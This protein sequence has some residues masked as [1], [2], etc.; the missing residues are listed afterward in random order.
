VTLLYKDALGTTSGGSVHVQLYPD[1]T[2]VWS[3]CFL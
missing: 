3:Y 2:R 1:W